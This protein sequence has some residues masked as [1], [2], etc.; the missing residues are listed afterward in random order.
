MMVFLS[1][2]YPERDWPTFELEIGKDAADKRTEE[3]LLPVLVS[4]E[5]PHIVGLPETTARV[6]MTNRS[7]EQIAELMAEKLDALASEVEQADT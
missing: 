5:V 3:Y 1:E 6:S 2:D 7:A 4:D